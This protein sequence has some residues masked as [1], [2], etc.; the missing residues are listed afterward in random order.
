M[1]NTFRGKKLKDIESA[2]ESIISNTDFLSTGTR[3]TGNSDTNITITGS[4]MQNNN[5]ENSIEEKKQ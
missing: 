4:H 3:I 1:N 2:P 5:F